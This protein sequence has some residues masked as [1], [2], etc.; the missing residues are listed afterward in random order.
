MLYI[1]LQN[2]KFYICRNISNVKHISNLE[3]RYLFC[4]FQ[5]GKCDCPALS[6]VFLQRW[7]QGM[8]LQLRPGS[9]GP[10]LREYGARHVTRGGVVFALVTRDTSSHTLVITP[11]GDLISLCEP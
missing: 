11:A 8:Q 4:L 5:C 3:F 6:R 1:H 10:V 7:L 2:S 9:R